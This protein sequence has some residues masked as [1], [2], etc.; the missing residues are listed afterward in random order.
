MCKL[1]G[2]RSTCLHFNFQ[3]FDL[4]LEIYCLRAYYVLKGQIISEIFFPKKQLVVRIIA[5][6]SK[7]GQIE[8]IKTLYYI[9]S[10]AKP[11]IYSSLI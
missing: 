7:M 2:T 8:K 6:A 10:R 4:L 3:S 1:Q 5:L 11:E 9:N